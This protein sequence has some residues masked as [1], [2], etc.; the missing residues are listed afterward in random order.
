MNTRMATRLTLTVC[1]LAALFVSAVRLPASACPVSSPPIG[2]GCRPGS[3]PSKA[4]CAASEK[5]KS[6]PKPPLAKEDSATQHL[7]AVVPAAVIASV[8]PM[9]ADDLR[10][11][12]SAH[13][14]AYSATPKRT[15]LCTFLI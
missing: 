6:L 15:L 3:C 11:D 4:C 14:V 9:R 1:M 10:R 2:E 5:N 12:S 8:A 13:A 7:V